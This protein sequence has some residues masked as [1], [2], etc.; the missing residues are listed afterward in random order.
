MATAGSSPTEG[1]FKGHGLAVLRAG[2]A[3]PGASPTSCAFTHL[4]AT[5]P[6]KLLSPSTSSRNA[7]ARSLRVAGAG[8]D[9]RKEDDGEEGQRQQKKAIAALYV[10]GYGGGLVSG[11][12]VSLDID[13]GSHCTLLLL[14]QGSTKVFKQRFSRG[15]IDG[16]GGTSQTFRLLVRRWA[17]LIVLP[18]PV[19]CFKRA[20]YDQTQRF[21]LRCAA[22]SSL[23]LLDWFTPG[24]THYQSARRDG[25]GAGGEGGAGAEAEEGGGSSS[26]RESGR[27]EGG[28]VGV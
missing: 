11:D 17:T 4:T 12:T 7:L 14:T 27:A 25:G 5:F 16:G 26:K 8:A 21:D 1:S 6:L 23:V 19:T 22:T 15:R 28:G 2:A 18:D 3:A 13:V 20:V 9:H 10:V 24:R